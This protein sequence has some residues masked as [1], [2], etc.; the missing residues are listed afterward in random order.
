MLTVKIKPI[1]LNYVMPSVI[2]QSGIMLRV[3]NTEWHYTEC[4]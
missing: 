1:Q 3:I 2:K 4:H